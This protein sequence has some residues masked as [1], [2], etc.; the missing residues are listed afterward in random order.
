MKKW[1]TAAC[2]MASLML[3]ACGGGGSPSEVGQ[4]VGSPLTLTGVVL[5]DAP[6]VNA[7]IEVRCNQNPRVQTTTSGQDGRYTITI[8]PTQEI[9]LSGA[10]AECVA[11]ATWTKNGVVR[12]T[13]SYAVNYEKKDS[14]RMNFNAAAGMWTWGMSRSYYDS[15]LSMERNQWKT[16]D[17]N[18]SV[19]NQTANFVLTRNPYLASIPSLL[20]DGFDQRPFALKPQS[21]A[22]ELGDAHALAVMQLARDLDMSAI[23]QEYIALNGGGSDE[24]PQF[25]H[26][27]PNTSFTRSAD[28]KVLITLAPK[29][30][31]SKEAFAYDDGQVWQSEIKD[32]NYMPVTVSLVTSQG[33]VH[34]MSE[35]MVRKNGGTS[36]ELGPEFNLDALP[37][38]TVLRIY[39]YKH[40]FGF[41][42][43][44]L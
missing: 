16:M 38:G 24:A 12:K 26:F 43:L 2:V 36:F 7:Q 14:L 30:S 17:M 44:R 15:K 4:S 8:A 9:P 19:L 21:Y 33:I 22:F 31:F 25:P 42:E 20:P 28:G 32:Y 41:A 3:A 29:S 13:E 11:R 1:K 27:L 18:E 23:S 40:V 5:W 39:V 10:A 35:V 6:I 37:S 34:S